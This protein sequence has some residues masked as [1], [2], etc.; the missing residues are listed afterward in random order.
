MP[1]FRY[2]TQ[3]IAGPRGKKRTSNKK[4]TSIQFVGNE[5]KFFVA[6]NDSRI[7]LYSLEN[8]SVI[9]KYVGH[10]SKESQMKMSTV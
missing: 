1:D 9:R 5:P 8:F 7:R 2:V 3:F 4:V 10:E 6:T